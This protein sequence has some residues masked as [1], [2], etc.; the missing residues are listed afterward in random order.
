VSETANS[1]GGCRCGKLRFRVEGA[2]LMYGVCHCSGC[3]RMTGSAYS[4]TSTYLEERF[5]VLAGN[6]VQGGLHG[7]ARHYHCDCC[8]SWIF[9]RAEMLGPFVNIRTTML[10]SPPTE[11]PFME[12]YTSEA[13]PWAVLG[14]KYAFE[15]FAEREQYEPLM[16]EFATATRQ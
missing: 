8:Y 13:L 7:D 12:S 9:T 5:E 6:P 4:L 2:P 14:A 10:D 11:T 1:N 16:R 15:K 3:Q